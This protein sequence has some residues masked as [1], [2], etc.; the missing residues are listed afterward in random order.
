MAKIIIIGGFLGSGKTTVLQEFLQ[1][2]SSCS[3]D[4]K[5][6]A[7]VIENEIGEYSIDDNVIREQGV[8]VKTI[9]SGC[10]CCSLQTSLIDGIT[11]ITDKYDPAYIIIETT[12]LAIPKKIKENLLQY[13]H[14]EVTICT[15]TDASRWEKLTR[16][17]AKGFIESQL[18]DADHIWINKTDTIDCN[19][20][21]FIMEDLKRY[22]NNAVIRA[23]S[24]KNGIEPTLFQELTQGE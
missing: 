16:S 11:E 5:I 2:L 24:A 10:I 12:G 9:Y 7:T 21:N 14:K 3:A 13:L 15:I 20:L 23:I 6:N 22:N 4:H 8:K 19:E 1:Y 17:F 18:A